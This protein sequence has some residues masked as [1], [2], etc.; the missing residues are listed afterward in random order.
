MSMS[1]KN[2]LAAAAVAAIIAA[3]GTASAMKVYGDAIEIY[4]TL[5]MSLDY[6]TDT[7]VAGADENIN[8]ASNSSNIGFRG[9]IPIEGTALKA[10]YRSE[11]LVNLDDGSGSFGS[12]DNY[13]GLDTPAGKFTFGY[14]STP[15]KIMGIIFTN[16]VTTAADP[17]TIL[18]A[19]SSGSLP[20]Y[21]LRSRNGVQWENTFAG[22]NV[23]L[24]YSANMF[25]DQDADGQDDNDA[26]MWNGSAIWKGPAGLRLGAA[27][28]RYDDA[29][30]TGAA[31]TG[32]SDAYR[33]GVAWGSGPLS[34]EAIFEDIDADAVP[35]LSRRVYGANVAFDI[36]K[37]TNIGAQWIHADESDAGNDEAD[38]LSVVLNQTFS[39]NLSAYALYST[40]LNDGGGTY[41]VTA[42]GHDN[43]RTA[44]GADAQV[45]SVGTVLKF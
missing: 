35:A 8:V 4:G 10:F 6:I 42:Y 7:E 11:H 5:H 1:M 13:I 22:V 18:G 45:F 14:I 43:V 33:L 32:E 29:A 37:G 2:S 28:L 36:M 20:R 41:R 23:K 31:V 3:P 16:Y 44:P 9:T 24:M 40:V 25:G 27:F 38:Q 26:S 30:R 17:F 34:A 15:Y 12:R 39:K 19:A 21:D